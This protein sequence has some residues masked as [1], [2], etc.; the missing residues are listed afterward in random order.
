MNASAGLALVALA[1]AAAGCDAALAPDSLTS[2]GSPILGGTPDTTTEAVMALIDQ[3]GS[4]AMTTASGCTGTTIAKMGSSGFLVTAAHCVVALQGNQVMLPVKLAAANTLFVVPGPDWMKGV[5]TNS[6]YSVAAVAIHPAYDG[7]VDSPFDVAMIRYLGVTAATQ[8]IPAISVAED[9]L[10]VNSTVRLVGYGKTES[11]S[12]NSVRRTVD[13]RIAQ[14]GARQF[15]YDQTDRKGACEGDSGGPTLFQTPGGPCVAGVISFGDVNC[16]TSGVSVRLSPVASFIQSFMS[17]MTPMLTC[18]ECTTVAV[19]PG[20]ACHDQGVTCSDPTTA[21]GKLLDCLLACQTGA[22]ATQC[23]TS[24][25]AGVPTFDALTKCQCGGACTTVCAQH[26][27][28]APPATPQM[29][30]GL[31]DPRA[32]CKSC[33]TGTCC[34]Q[35]ATCGSDAACASCQRQPSSACRFNISFMT[36]NDCLATCAGKPCAATTAPPSDGG[37]T[38][39]GGAPADASVT[40]DAADPVDAGGPPPAHASNGSGC[41]LAAGAEPVSAWS[42]FAIGALALIS[43]PLAPPLGNDSPARCPFS[44]GV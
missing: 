25:P 31:A 43:A 19:S 6:Y 24:M 42:V 12:Q 18:E 40:T 20:N 34:A 15:S 37:A 2:R 39:D 1:V 35:A 11:S 8:V 36:L 44:G 27:A 4:G 22:C 5:A 26:P 16:T 9:T 29:C 38:L 10:A 23:R 17:G 28:C 7:A 13:R 21:C 33:I 41:A 3:S 14:L 30:G 32:A